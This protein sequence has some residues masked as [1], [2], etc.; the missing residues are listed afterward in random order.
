MAA[1]VSLIGGGGGGIGTVPSKVTVAEAELKITLVQLSM[2][3]RFLSGQPDFKIWSS[4]WTTRN[5]RKN[6][7]KVISGKLKVCKSS[8]K[9][10]T[11]GTQCAL[12]SDYVCAGSAAG[13]RAVKQRKLMCLD[14]CHIEEVTCNFEEI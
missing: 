9:P 12:L 13:S 4:G 8:S 3:T 7:Q 10:C 14:S 2:T 6:F 11:V 5:F 1:E